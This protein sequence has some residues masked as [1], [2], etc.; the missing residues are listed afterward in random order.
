M[1]LAAA[2]GGAR[3]P[4]RPD[5]DPR[6]QVPRRPPEV[7]R[8]GRVVDRTR[9]SSEDGGIGGIRSVEAIAAVR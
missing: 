5:V 3:G 2:S 1:P 7:G 9:G 4:S 8:P 6:V